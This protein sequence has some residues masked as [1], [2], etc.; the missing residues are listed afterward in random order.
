MS[1]ASGQ[2]RPLLPFDAIALARHRD[3][4][5]RMAA[6][7]HEA[8]QLLYLEFSSIVNGIVRRI[9]EDP[10]DAREA[11]QDTFIKAWR[12]AESFQSDRG[13]VIAWLVFIARHTAIDRV[14]KGARQR[15]LYAMLKREAFEAEAA[16]PERGELREDLAQRM[17]ALSDRQRQALE[18]AFFGGCTQAQIAAAMRTPIGN[19]KNHL[20]RGLQKLRE[21]VHRP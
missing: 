15:H 6:G 21:I 4:V 16:P 18:L 10:E 3:L 2:S 12:N 17:T 9:L 1:E 20:R 19:V 7:D 5:A 14:R 13:E 11:V 8:L